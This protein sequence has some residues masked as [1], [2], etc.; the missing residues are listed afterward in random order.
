MRAGRTTHRQQAV[1][2][3]S[4]RMRPASGARR[5]RRI[6]WVLWLASLGLLALSGV[7]LVLSASTSVRLTFG[8]RGVD[9]I[10]GQRSPQSEW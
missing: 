6:A 1:A 3:T 8:F 2:V 10:L 9:L 5:V 4:P 7:L